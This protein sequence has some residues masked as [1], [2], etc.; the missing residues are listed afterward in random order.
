MDDGRGYSHCDDGMRP[1]LGLVG[2]QER[3]VLLGARLHVSNRRRGG[4]VL[5]VTLPRRSLG[6]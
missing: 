4:G 1:G 2:I 6:Q 3:A 5:S